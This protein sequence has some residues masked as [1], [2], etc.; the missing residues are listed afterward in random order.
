[1]LIV[2]LPLGLLRDSVDVLLEATPKGVD[3]AEVARHIR[4]APG[5]QEVHDPHA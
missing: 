3:M 1:V 2:P 4:E 5:V